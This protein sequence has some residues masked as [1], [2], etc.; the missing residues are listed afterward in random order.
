MSLRKRCPLP[1]FSR[2]RHQNSWV[3]RLLW[4]VMASRI[5]P[6]WHNPMWSWPLEQVPKLP[7]K[8][9]IVSSWIDKTPG[10]GTL[11][12]VYTFHKPYSDGYNSKWSFLLYT[13]VSAYLW[14]PEA[15][16]I[17]TDT[18]P[19]HPCCQCDGPLFLFRCY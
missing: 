16:S 18:A 3:I 15:L 11:L 17:R 4:L 9:P 2:Y 12:R 5:W 13:T 6:H 7:P 8:P 10:Y 1:R 19:S 14:Q